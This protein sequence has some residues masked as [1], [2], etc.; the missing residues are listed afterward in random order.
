MD[1]ANFVDS[2]FGTAARV[3]GEKYA[4]TYYLPKS[5]PRDLALSA[6][7][8]AALSEADAALGNLQGLATLIT[9]PSLL[10]GPYLRR[11]AL[12]SSRIEGTQTSLSELFQSEIDALVQNDDTLEVTRYLQATSQAYELAQSLP[13]TQRLILQ[14]HATL[15][16]GVRGE[17]KM[18]GE[19]RRSPVWVGSAGATP[20][21][22]TFVPPLPQHLGDLLADWERFV[23]DDGIHLPA[24]IQAALMHYQFETIHPFLDGNGRIGRLLINLLLMQRGRL[25]H[26]LLYLSHFF[27][28]HRDEYYDRLQAVR[29]RAEIQEWFIFFL[30]AVKAQAFDAITRARRLITIRE[31]YTA[32]AMQERSNL[33][34]LVDIIVSNPFVTTKY[35]ETELQIT[36]QGARKLIR[37]AEARGWL[38]SLGTGGRGGREL[39]VAY[40]I[41]ETIEAPMSYDGPGAR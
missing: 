23:N 38:R 40:A 10:I 32:E 15:M 13:L 28:T 22:A 5:I 7:V 36:N 35:V 26:P 33:R 14:V 27:E 34:R 17:E 30:E 21:T 4:F 8:I 24:L 16:Q 12:A 9:Q 2:V 6:P 37:N 11:E 19:F 20:E 3:P 25:P 29:E 18:P 39:W 1:E 31:E 41:F